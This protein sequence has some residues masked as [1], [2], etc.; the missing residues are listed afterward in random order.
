MCCEHLMVMT[1]FKGLKLDPFQIESFEKISK[2]ESIIVSAPTGSGK[3]LLIDYAIHL[4]LNNDEM[5]H[6]QKKRII[7]T[8]PIKALSNQKYRDFCRDYGKE[9][10][11]IM[12]GDVSINRE[13]QILIMTTEIL[14]NI[15]YLSPNDPLLNDLNFVVFDEIHYLNDP[16]RGVV[17]E[18]SLILLPEEIPLILLSATIPN[19]KEITDWL[20]SFK[21]KKQISLITS[22]ERPVPLETYYFDGNI[23]P[24]TDKIELNAKQRRKRLK[25]QKKYVEFQHELP[26]VYGNDTFSPVEVL[27]KLDLE[28]LPAIYFIFSRKACEKAAQ[29]VRQNH[30]NLLTEEEKKLIQQRITAFRVSIGNTDM[31]TQIENALDILLSGI[32]FH[33]AGCVPLLKEFIE[34]LFAEGLIKILFATETFAMGLNL[35]ARTVIFH[36]LEKFDGTEFRYLTSSEFHQMAGRAGR[37]GID[38]IGNA[39]VVLSIS[40]DEDEIR[41]II[42]GTPEPLESQFRLSYNAIANLLES[43]NEDEIV[44]LLQSSFK[45]YS[46]SK[47]RESKNT[48]LQKQIERLH[49][50]LSV[51]LQC[52]K[53]LSSVNAWNALGRLATLE[54]EYSVLKSQIKLDF[55]SP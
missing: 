5:F 31:L 15:L 34:S 44:N 48:E 26:L 16:S 38:A 4:T 25:K 14:R 8:S 18:E 30:L 10:I 45:E 19:G 13:A 17:W 20:N 21:K 53:D 37:R 49:E 54:Q 22:F 24:Y 32:A 23:H 29:A 3:T 2:S 39:I 40:S 11:G 50:K 41:S 12:T 52:S 51:P 35:P 33:H 28:Y 42:K 6:N 7:Y 36:A 27:K 9:N 43:R 1:S 47:I 55:C 46:A